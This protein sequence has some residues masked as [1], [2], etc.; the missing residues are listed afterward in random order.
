[1]GTPRAKI[2]EQ[3]VSKGRGW[4]PGG[5]SA[6]VS[7]LPREVPDFTSRSCIGPRH[8]DESAPCLVAWPKDVQER[9]KQDK[10]AR[11]PGQS[12]VAS[13][14]K[15]ATKH[16]LKNSDAKLLGSHYWPRCGKARFIFER[17]RHF[18]PFLNVLNA[19]PTT[20][21]RQRPE[22][23]SPPRTPPRAPSCAC[24]VGAMDMAR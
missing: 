11:P 2:H 5:C 15:K 6:L 14:W 21:R 18:G 9:P 17:S 20:T 16:V 10:C 3:S 7:C 23:R 1:M 8:T 19:P 22:I 13:Q 24:A 12:A 4:S